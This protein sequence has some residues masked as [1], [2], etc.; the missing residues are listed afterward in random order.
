MA[1][2]ELRIIIINQL[3]TMNITEYWMN[4]DYWMD[5]D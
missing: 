3:M 2:S 1:D 5:G 4:I